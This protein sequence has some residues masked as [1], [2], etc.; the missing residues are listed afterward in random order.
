MVAELRSQG[1]SLRAIAGAAGVDAKTVRNDLSG[2]DISPP[3][4]VVGADG[5][6]YPSAR[7]ARVQQ[8]AELLA[9]AEPARLDDDLIAEAEAIAET[10][11]EI[12]DGVAEAVGSRRVPIAVPK[13][14][15]ADDIPPHPATYPRAVMDL[16][17][18]SVI[19]YAGHNATPAPAPTGHM[20]GDI[21]FQR[22]ARQQLRDADR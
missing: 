7:P 1:H 15:V 8:A 17:A 20:I 4:T 9:E 19:M 2:G 22:A 12:E 16:F 6:R 13:R 10:A 21:A 3:D 18:A 5:K 14:Q 11:T